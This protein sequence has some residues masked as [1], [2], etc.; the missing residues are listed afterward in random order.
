MWQIRDETVA[1]EKFELRTAVSPHYG[2]DFRIRA[3]FPYRDRNRNHDR[4][5]ILNPCLE[6][7]R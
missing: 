7:Q 1:S 3:I 5:R 6:C 4:D 2:R